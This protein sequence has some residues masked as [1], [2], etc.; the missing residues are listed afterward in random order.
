MIE[1]SPSCVGTTQ[2]PA[3]SWA[4]FSPCLGK[5]LCCRCS[6]LSVVQLCLPYEAPDALDALS[7][8]LCGRCVPA[9]TRAS[10]EGCWRQVHG[11]VWEWTSCLRADILFWVCVLVRSSSVSLPYLGWLVERRPALRA[12]VGTHSS[13]PRLGMFPWLRQRHKKVIRNT[14]TP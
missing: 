12:E 10:G 7:V 3:A 9:V 14:E 8:R 6:S 11:E 13:H 1:M 2:N 4:A 5:G